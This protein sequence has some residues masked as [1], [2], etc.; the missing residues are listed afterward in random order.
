MLSVIKLNVIFAECPNE[1]QY[2]EYHYAECHYAECH[3][4]E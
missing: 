1:V 2:V 3:Y 4:I